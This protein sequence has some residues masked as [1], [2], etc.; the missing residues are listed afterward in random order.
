MGIPSV[1]QQLTRAL[2]AGVPAAWVT[3]DEFYGNHRG[4]RR[5]LQGRG[6]GYVLAVARNHR[7]TLTDGTT[8]TVE[9]VAGR[10]PQRSWNRL[11]AGK[12]AKGD[13]VYDW[14]WVR[15]TPPGDETTGH[16]W[17]L[18]RRRIRDGE[19]AFYR[20]WSPTPVSLATLVRVAG[21]RCCVEECFRAGKDRSAWT[22]TRSAHGPPGTAT[23]PWPCSPTPSSP[24]SPRANAPTAQPVHNS[25][26][27]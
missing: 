4:L 14:A 26:S 20:C 13:R 5:D 18:A 8:S 9:R 27:P 17:L 21:T 7:V 3:A 19:L 15:I 16:H 25:W 11:S 2:D 1:V 10:L 22:S 6:L 24:S 23:P 12:G